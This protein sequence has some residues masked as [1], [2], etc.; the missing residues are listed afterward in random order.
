MTWEG[1]EAVDAD[2]GWIQ[3][4]DRVGKVGRCASADST[5]EDIAV[6]DPAIVVAVAAKSDGVLEQRSQAQV[7]QIDVGHRQAKRLSGDRNGGSHSIWGKHLSGDGVRKDALR[8]T[9]S[10][11]LVREGALNEAF[12]SHA[13]HL[14]DGSEGEADNLMLD[15]SLDQIKAES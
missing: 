3:E 2:G 12:F 1:G 11:E 9:V 5:G 13:S 6:M 8:N 10:E 15:S 4:E 14:G 7:H